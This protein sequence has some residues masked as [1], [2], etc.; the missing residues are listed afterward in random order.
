MYTIIEEA[1]D[2]VEQIMVDVKLLQFLTYFTWS[3]MEMVKKKAFFLRCIIVIG[4]K[5]QF[6][7]KKTVRQDQGLVFENSA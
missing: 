3:I 6:N 4:I 1:K 5:I 7:L 2:K